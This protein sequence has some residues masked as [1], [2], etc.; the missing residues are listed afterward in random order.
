MISPGASP[1]LRRSS[2]TSARKRASTGSAPYSRPKSKKKMQTVRSPVMKGG[3]PEADRQSDQVGQLPTPAPAVNAVGAGPNPFA[4]LGQG[5]GHVDGQLAPPAPVAVDLLAQMQNMMG[6]MLVGME[7][8]LI[9]AS[10]ELRSSVDQAMVS[11]SDL[12]ARMTSNE[13]RMDVVVNEIEAMVERKVEE[14]PKNHGLP[15]SRAQDMEVGSITMDESL[16]TGSR[17]YAAVAGGR[18]EASRE[19]RREVEYWRSRKSFRL[20]PVGTRLRWRSST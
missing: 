10:N 17:S 5:G 15:L 6:G 13:K 20:R 12:S 19:D 9:K 2:R 11:I 7:S 4:S 16:T 18:Q 14:G 3:Q 8:R 1:E